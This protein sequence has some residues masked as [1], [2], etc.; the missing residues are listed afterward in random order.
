MER[1]IRGLSYCIERNVTKQEF[2]Q[3]KKGSEE[4]IA[5]MQQLCCSVLQRCWHDVVDAID[6]P[7]THDYRSVIMRIKEVVLQMTAGL[8]KSNFFIAL[9]SGSSESSA[10]TLYLS[11]SRLKENLQASHCKCKSFLC[12]QSVVSVLKAARF[13]TPEY[14]DNLNKFSWKIRASGRGYFRRNRTVS[15][16]LQETE[17]CCGTGCLNG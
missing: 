4:E 8:A 13:Y 5:F 6:S 12:L 15:K 9:A 3:R 1:E 17:L 10:K 2:H 7:A 16:R 11:G 14:R